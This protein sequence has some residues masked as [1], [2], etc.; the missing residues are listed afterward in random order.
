MNNKI[1]IKKKLYINGVEKNANSKQTMKHDRQNN[2]I[3][4]KFQLEKNI[5][6]VKKLLTVKLRQ[7]RNRLLLCE[8]LDCQ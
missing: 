1:K 7:N 6:G 5:F 8:L 3:S 2:S 4:M